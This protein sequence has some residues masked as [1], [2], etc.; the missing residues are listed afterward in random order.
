MLFVGRVSQRQPG[1]DDTST[2]ASDVDGDEQATNHV[3]G[4]G[5]DQIPDE[6]D[7]DVLEDESASQGDHGP[8]IS[9]PS[10]ASTAAAD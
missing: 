2:I 1:K 8:K 9:P 3:D 10:S 5:D 7:R 4:H 6:T